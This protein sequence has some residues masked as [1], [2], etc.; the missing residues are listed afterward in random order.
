[1][2]RVVAQYP[3]MADPQFIAAIEQAIQTQVPPEHKP[4]FQQRLDDLKRIAAARG[5]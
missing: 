1:M 5:Q 2:R 3:L 4:T